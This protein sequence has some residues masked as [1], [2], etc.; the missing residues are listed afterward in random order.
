MRRQLKIT[1]SL[2]QPKTPYTELGPTRNGL[3][4]EALPASMLMAVHGSTRFLWHLDI[5][6]QAQLAPFFPRQEASSIANEFPGAS[7]EPLCPSACKV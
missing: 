5:R 3:M 4:L 6:V 1:R 7:P 2:H